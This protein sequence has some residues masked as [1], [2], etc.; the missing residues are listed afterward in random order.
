LRRTRAAL[1]RSSPA[2]QETVALA[3][4]LARALGLRHTP[5]VRLSSDVATPL[6]TG[7]VRPQILLP[8]KGATLPADEQRMALCH[9]LSHVKRQDLWLG[10]I[11]AIAERLFFFHPLVRLAAREYSLC[12]EAACDAAVMDTLSASPR[13]Y[14]RLMLS[15]GV[16]KPRAGM[17]LSGAAT[18]H[19]M[20]KRRIT[21]LCDSMPARGRGR[22]VSAIAIAATIASIVPLRLVA[23]A[24]APAAAIEA[25][26]STASTTV[27][28]P[29]DF[30][31]HAWVHHV[32]KMFIGM[33]PAWLASGSHERGAPAQGNQGRQRDLNYVLFIDEHDTNMSGSTSDIELARKY[34]RGNERLLWFR[35]NGGEFV[36]RDARVLDQIDDIW[37]PVGEVGAAQGE[38]GAKQGLLGAKQGGFGAQQGVVGAQQGTLGAQQGD[39]GARQGVLAERE[40]RARTDAERQAI[41]AEQRKIDDEIRGLDEQMR[42]L[43][44][45]MREF[46]EPMRALDKQMRVLDVEMRALDTKMRE[47]TDRAQSQM[48]ELVERAIASGA[49]ERVR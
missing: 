28:A 14:G 35:H 22:L 30:D 13:D 24:Q 23:R 25:P 29:T 46:D 31:L 11:P 18:S 47:A 42:A 32:G 7:I 36:V 2:G 26:K 6:V 20:L 9:E 16:S 19:S 27:P 48:R 12:R 17:A 40:A 41:R 21:M 44:A 1:R 39:L 45:K 8:S 15:L 10:L 38:V 49:A 5:I 33:G 34:R 3:S 4:T 43:D 37:R